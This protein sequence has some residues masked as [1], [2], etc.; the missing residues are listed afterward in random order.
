MIYEESY[1]SDN[2]SSKMKSPSKNLP[3]KSPISYK[4][5]PNMKNK[6]E[7]ED[8]H[9]EVNEGLYIKEIE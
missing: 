5:S 9:T 2:E 4:N 7:E 8:L 3:P 1:R 6:I